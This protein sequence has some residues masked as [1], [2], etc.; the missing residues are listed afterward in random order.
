[1]IKKFVLVPAALI[2]T[3]FSIPSI[4]KDA[5]D[6]PLQISE[7]QLK[8]LSQAVHQAR[9]EANGLIIEVTREDG[10]EG[11]EIDFIGTDIIPIIPATAEGFGGSYLPPRPRYLNLHMT[12][13]SN[14]MPLVQ[15]EINALKAPDSDEAAKIVPFLTE[16]KSVFGDAQ[17]HLAALGPLTTTLP[18]DQKGI[19]TEAS[20]LNKD[21]DQIE[22][23]KKDMYKS[24]KS[25]PDKGNG[26]NGAKN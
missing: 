25:D 1:M 17:K 24:Y 19:A 10:L 26:G 22:K 8:D 4:A 16:I 12:N 21:L 23:L 20:A 9:H 13:L 15:D 3:A 18:Y 6:T 5:V 11:G 7:R 14:E 2:L